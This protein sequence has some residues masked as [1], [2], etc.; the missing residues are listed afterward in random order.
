[1]KGLD[2]TRE[3]YGPVAVAFHWLVAVLVVGLLALG[4]YMAR[5]PDAGFDKKKIVLI[6]YHKEYG[7]LVL[8]LVAARIAWR[9]RGPLPWLEKAPAWQKL[10]ARFVHL[11][12]YALLIALPLTGW[13]MSSAAS[14]PVSFFGLGY[15]PDLLPHDDYLFHAFI[16]IHKWLAY[17]L[18]ALLAVHAGAA[19][20]HHYVKRDATLKKM[21]PD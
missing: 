6:L 8:L 19:L 12:L 3:R 17:T 5:L 16:A 10:A 9:S 4:L 11:W 15:L 13:L 18:I 2:N 14:L 21:L 20:W 1:M 7:I